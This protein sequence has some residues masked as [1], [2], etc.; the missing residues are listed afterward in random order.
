MNKMFAFCIL[1][2]GGCVSG[3][4][5][6]CAEEVSRVVWGTP[7]LAETTEVLG[8]ILRIRLVE[9]FP[10]RSVRDFWPLY[11]DSVGD[12]NVEGEFVW[13]A[14]SDRGSQSR[15][16]QIWHPGQAEVWRAKFGDQLVCVPAPN[17]TTGMAMDPGGL[18]L[19]IS[20]P[21]FPLARPRA[22]K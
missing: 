18:A 6:P 8:R 5:E 21:G 2:A 13:L 12:Q 10:P 14:R 9:S 15:L 16:W 3:L 7:D 11:P 4:E 17:S 1:A 22:S 20:D 19:W